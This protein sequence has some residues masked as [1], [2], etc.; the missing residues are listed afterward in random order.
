MNPANRLFSEIRN[1]A[2]IGG[3]GLAT[4]Y[5]VTVGRHLPTVFRSRSL[6]CV[7]HAFGNA[8]GWFIANA[9]GISVCVP[10]DSI[11][12]VRELYGNGA[13][14][15][16]ASFRIQ[17][18]ENVVDLGANCGV[19]TALAAK[20]GGRVLAVEAQFGYMVELHEILDRNGCQA[21]LEWAL[22]GPSSGTFANAETPKRLDHFEGRTPPTVS[23]ADLLYRHRMERVDFLK[24]DIEG[25]EFDL[26]FKDNEWLSRVR[27]I[28][29]EV[30]PTCGDPATLRELLVRR[31][32][33]VSMRDDDIP[34]DSIDARPQVLYAT[35]DRAD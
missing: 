7:D 17:P 6:N 20:L 24:C 32:F 31:G 33:T 4:Q 12:L 8:G 10:R 21:D 9:F 29:M 22:V 30:H 3:I 23:M 28:A 34:D 15:P 14:F 35:T 16:S 1:V 18:G 5:T 27:R 11:G 26:F 2:A 25:S 13:Y 19:F